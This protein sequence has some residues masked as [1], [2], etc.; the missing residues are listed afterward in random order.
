MMNSFREMPY[1]PRS[2]KEGLECYGAIKEPFFSQGLVVDIIEVV[3]FNELDL[4]REKF[5]RDW[6]RDGFHQAARWRF[7]TGGL[8]ES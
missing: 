8:V 6:R 7:K 3:W 4:K 5:L 1:F 2:E